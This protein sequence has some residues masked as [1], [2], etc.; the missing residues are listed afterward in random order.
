VFDLLD[1]VRILAG[2][3]SNQ[4]KERAELEAM[5]EEGLRRLL[6][7]AAEKVPFYR[8]S[9]KGTKVRDLEHLDSLPVL[10]KEDIRDHGASMLCSDH[11]PLRQYSTSGST[12]IPVTI[13][14]SRHELNYKLALGYLQ[15]SESGLGPFDSQAR[16][17][18][19]R[20][21]P[22]ILQRMGLFRNHY[23]PIKNSMKENLLALKRLRPEALHSCSSVLSPLAQENLASN[24]PINIDKVFSYA[25]VLS[26]KARELLKES[27]HCSVHDLY[28]A[29]ETGWIAWECEEGNM[30]LHSDSIIAE[31]VD[32][33]GIPVKRGQ[34]GSLVLTSLWKR[35]MPLIRY[36]IGDRTSF[37]SSCR[38]GR[39]LHV[40]RPIEGRED[41]L[42]VLPSG[43]SYTVRDTN[44]NA[45]PGIQQFQIFQDRP[46]E[47]VI[48]IVPNG[49]FSMQDE[50]V[51]QVSSAMPEPMEVTVELVDSIPR[52]PT[53]KI[54]SIVSK[55]KPPGQDA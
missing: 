32:D 49:R 17:T 26:G 6:E 52:G 45:L 39:G 14:F 27:F 5:Q 29:T 18:H 42:I 4:W 38:C 19:Y 3:K 11:G 34:T 55:V 36:A 7:H 25:E 24:D 10:R 23:L 28:G 31:I 47:L 37:G 46:G 15:L 43:A 21:E 35:S 1:S 13:H 20:L 51:R 8:K 54:C 30:H 2:L 41:D 44:I 48:K 33:A 53:G 40:L 9:L 22:N 16:I 50:L 12:G